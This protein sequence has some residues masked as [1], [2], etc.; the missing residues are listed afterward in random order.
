MATFDTTVGGA[1]ANS[2][3]TVAEADDY[4]LERRLHVGT[5]W[6]DLGNDEREAALMWAAQVLDQYNFV[7]SIADETQAL[8]W[9][10]IDAY[11]KDG[12]LVASD[13]IPNIVKDA[14]AEIAYS[15]VGNQT[16]AGQPA[17][18]GYEEVQVGPIRVKF[19]DPAGQGDILDQVPKDVRNM[20]KRY[21]AG[22]GIRI[23]VIRA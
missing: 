2:Y 10:R 6:S 16:I 15:L 19:R 11:T 8:Q 14:Q 3:A 20:L 13:E 23:P 4:L 18:E 5:A 22:F 9:P 1:A 7:G 21:L 17:G 12:R